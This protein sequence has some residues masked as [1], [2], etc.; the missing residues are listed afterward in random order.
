MNQHAQTL[1]NIWNTLL[2]NQSIEICTEE[3]K[4][5]GIPDM[6]LLKL[7]YLH[8]EYKLKDYLKCLAIPNSTLTNM[9]N[10]LEKK[11]FLIRT[12]D[13]TDLRS[14]GLELTAHGKCSIQEHFKQ[15]ELLFEQMLQPLSDSEQSAFLAL[16]TK[17]IQSLPET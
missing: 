9:I 6:K 17:L 10:R 11:E 3:L 2:L 13:K 5:L 7:C 4:G 14:F 1:C 8:P 12:I 16:F 15:E